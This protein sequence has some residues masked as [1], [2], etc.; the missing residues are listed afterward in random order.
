MA[1]D[2]QEIIDILEEI[3]LR[4]LSLPIDRESSSAIDSATFL[5][6]FVKERVC[7]VCG[8]VHVDRN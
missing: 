7:P 1:R 4:T 8:G 2:R 3:R 6:E 5:I